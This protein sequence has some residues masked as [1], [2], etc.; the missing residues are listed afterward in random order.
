VARDSGSGEA[1]RWHVD[2]QHLL[3][4]L[5]F[6]GYAGL[7]LLV[8]VA[9]MRR[10]GGPQPPVPTDPPADMA[11]PP[12]VLPPLAAGGTTHA[13]QRALAEQDQAQ[14]RQRADGA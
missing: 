7:L 13:E 8:V 12:D 9:L 4:D 14:I 6:W 2:S 1:A 11:A 3:A 5:L 10:A